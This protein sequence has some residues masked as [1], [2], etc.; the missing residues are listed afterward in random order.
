[1]GG[2]STFNWYVWGLLESQSASERFHPLKA[3]LRRSLDEHEAAV[4]VRRSRSV[5]GEITKLDLRTRKI[6]LFASSCTFLRASPCTSDKPILP[7]YIDNPFNG[8]TQDYG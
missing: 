7:I 2:R 3:P 8:A 6:G 1:M 5:A 4:A